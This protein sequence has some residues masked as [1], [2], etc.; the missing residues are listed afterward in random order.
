MFGSYYRLYQVFDKLN[1]PEQRDH[2]QKQMD[3]TGLKLK[4]TSPF[5][6]T[7]VVSLAN[8][9]LHYAPPA[10]YYPRHGYEATECLLAPEWEKAFEGVV[11]DIFDALE[12]GG[13]IG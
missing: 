2:Y 4:K 10:S 9:Y 12:I 5:D 8:G 13:D 1:D 6:R 11:Q 7:Y 3:A